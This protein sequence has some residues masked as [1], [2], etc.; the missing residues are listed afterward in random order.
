MVRG[1]FFSQPLTLWTTGALPSVL[2][3]HSVSYPLDHSPVVI[4]LSFGTLLVPVASFSLCSTGYGPCA[5]VTLLYI[6]L[7]ILSGFLFAV[8]HFLATPHCCIII[9]LVPLPYLLSFLTCSP[10]CATYATPYLTPSL[11]LPSSL[12]IIITN[13]LNL[14]RSRPGFVLRACGF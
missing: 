11:P 13:L 12:S 2:C 4:E 10:T 8:P 9:F 7:L 5:L 3:I 6:I 1:H 14:R